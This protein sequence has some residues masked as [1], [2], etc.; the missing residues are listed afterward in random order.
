MR[1]RDIVQFFAMVSVGDTV[2]IHGQRDEQVAEIFGGQASEPTEVAQAEASS[3]G[4]AG[5]Q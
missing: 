3:A 4:V 1:N 2:E 5:G